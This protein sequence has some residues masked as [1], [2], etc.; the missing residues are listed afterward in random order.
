MR[1][2]SHAVSARLELISENQTGKP[3]RRNQRFLFV[4][5][6]GRLAAA[7]FSSIV[8]CGVFARRQSDDV[9]GC[10]VKTTSIAD[11]ND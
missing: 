11:F 6:A 3:S 9:G 2:R 5:N 8:L 7:I 4:M 10:R 1:V